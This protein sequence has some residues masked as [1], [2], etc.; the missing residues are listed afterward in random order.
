MSP[1]QEREVVRD[2]RRAAPCG[3]DHCVEVAQANHGVVIRNSKDPGGA[4]LHYKS[5]EWRSFLEGAK[6]GDFDDL[7]DP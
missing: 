2:W 4:L 5:D 1:P 3:A 6:R 7:I